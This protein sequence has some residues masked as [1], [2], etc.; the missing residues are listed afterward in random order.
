MYKKIR[1]KIIY[2]GVKSFVAARRFMPFLW[3]TIIL[4]F[5]FHDRLP[6]NYFDSGWQNIVAGIFFVLC[7]SLAFSGSLLVILGIPITEFVYRKR[8]KKWT[9]LEIIGNIPSVL[10]TLFIFLLIIRCLEDNYFS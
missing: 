7:S 8:L 3:V 10:A 1:H 2:Y 5:V 4:G 9:L 6:V